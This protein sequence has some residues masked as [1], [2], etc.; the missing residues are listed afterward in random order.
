VSP[1]LGIAR[2]RWCVSLAGTVLLAGTAWFFAPLLPLFEDWPPRL[3]LIAA[4]LAIW[5]G[6]NA[7]LDTVRRRRDTAL[8]RGIGAS[9]EET[10]EAQALRARLTAA[11]DLLK[12]TLRG[13]G[14]LYE[15][16]WYA[17]IGPPG[18][19]KTTALLNA[20]L[21]F[22]LAGQMG[23]GAVAGVGGTRMCDWWFTE[24]AV[25]I[26][27]AGRYTTQDSNATIDRAGWNAFLALLKET[28][29][30]Q[31]LNGLLVAFPL[32]DIAQAPAAE[33]KAHAAAIRG[34]VNELQT[35]FGLRMPVYML[36]TKADL[37]A[38]FT[39]FFDDLDRD[40]RAQVWG[41][42][43]GLAQDAAAAVA[44]FPGE[45]RALVQR[46]NT[47]LFDRM[48][49]ER[50]PDRRARIA[51]F[52]GQLA[53]LEAVLTE[54]LH[55][56][57]DGTREDPAPLLRGVYF[58]SG[59][60]EGTPFDRLTGTLART[61]G[62]DRTATRSLQPVQGR[63]YFLE[64]LLKQVIFGEALLV[65]NSPAATRRRV[66]LRA[67]GYGT[68]C[69]L[70]AATAGVVWQA[71][72]AG[73]RAID[74]AAAALAGYQQTARGLPLDPVG[75]ADLGRLAPLLDQASALSRDT[76][77]PSWRPAMLS[78]REKLD[79]S[80]RT[81]YRHALERALLPRL[82]WRLE[83][84]LRGNLNRADFLYEAT[85]VYLML[86]N[87]GPLDAALVREWMS[88][89][90][91]TAY[92]GV[93]YAPL[94][95][96]LLRHLDA[97]LAEPLSQV[98]LDGELV[99]VAR[100]RI[101]TVP[102]AQR[103]YSRIRP[104]AAAQRLPPWRPSDALGPAGV[105]L[106]VRASGKKLTDGIAGF[107]T[108]D[109]FHKVLLPSLAGA[110]KTVVSESW[111]LGD[112]VAFDPNGPQMQAL[113]RD[114]IALY[115]AEYAQAWDLMLTDLN[116]VQLRSLSQAA[117]DLYI[118]AS[119]E[120]PM[121]ALLASVARQLTLS[122][123]PGGA[124]PATGAEASAAAGA[125]ARLREVLGAAQSAAPAAAAPPGHEIDER[126]QALREL[127]GSGPAAP[128][129]L[130]LRSLGDTQQQIAKLAATLVS[131][132]AATAASGGIDP[133][134]ALKSDALRQPQPLARWLTEI[135]T[136]A[137]ALRS[138]DPRQQ[139]VTMFNAS[140]GLGEACPAVVNGHYPFTPAATDDVSVADFARLFAPGGAFDGFVN[141]LLRRYVDTSAKPW[142]LLSADA[143]AAPVTP[144][145]LSQ[146]QRAAAIRDVFF[147]DGETR[148]R[149]RLDIT[150][151]SVDAATRQATLDLDGTSIGYSRGV[152]HATQVTW[153]SFN[154][155]PTMR[156]LFDPPP[157]G[158][159]GELRES[160]PWALFRLL[161]HGKPQAQSGTT[162]RYTLTFQFGERQAVFDVRVA[163]S[164]NPLT[165]GLLQDFHC[166]GVRAN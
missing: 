54:F 121:R 113:Q 87:A 151:V 12:Q 26:D 106:F 93:G 152:Q 72:S 5:G 124:R 73:Q 109:G 126:Y 84:Q 16:P 15:Q 67:A 65:A 64:H 149:V 159:T 137:A 131:S 8:T 95:A 48:Q 58:T 108:V 2:S 47:R 7:W 133:L 157:A 116:V 20:G 6:G 164:A 11:L 139:L 88:L 99:N 32:G 158:R 17:I 14:Y 44:E 163:A 129:D 70:V 110:A 37:I 144:A 77:E 104:S 150:P 135:A 140:G 63:S 83:T 136:S 153:P 148:P 146:F 120:S 141:T 125:D 128:I 156:L 96:S 145:D 127:A 138:G 35:R 81:V 18:A 42:T 39:E 74:A 123:P 56:A 147:A 49:A 52:P 130:V 29:P 19:G 143:A 50:N 25:L 78:Q 118:L 103:V 41:T 22:P 27:T 112:R 66:A 162:D 55:D 60:Q 4:L 53:S 114:V 89:D 102:L 90:W 165:P 82:M 69:L 59:T 154:L 10:A 107:L 57:F 75:D 142:R 28:R 23:Q 62:V 9:A 51:L 34:R 155:Q 45:L 31:P 91:Q 86:G 46:L 100:G 40:G 21:R 61:L 76:G 43:F 98:Q 160:G 36:F 80:A 134:L 33:R 24:D 13:R 101:A 79:A 38:G 161:A 97:L 3:A 119:P 71:R 132:G 111:V 122:V 85:R 92:P 68:A 105:P 166:P 94:R 117:Q 30:R 1:L 115:E